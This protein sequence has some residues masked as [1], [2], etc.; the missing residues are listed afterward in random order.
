VDNKLRIIVE[1]EQRDDGRTGISVGQV[2]HEDVKLSFGD[3]AMILGG[4]IVMLSR[5]SEKECGM[6]DYELMESVIANMNKEFVSYESFDDA[7]LFKRSTN[8]TKDTE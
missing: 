3:M 2:Q 1:V 6:K 7:K 8:E 4:A 5:L